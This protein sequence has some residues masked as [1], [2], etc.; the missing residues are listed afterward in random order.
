[1]CGSQNQGVIKLLISFL[2]YF[3]H[4]FPLIIHEFVINYYMRNYMGH[5]MIIICLLITFFLGN[6]FS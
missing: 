5:Y 2:T 4:E 6:E 3:E 1:M